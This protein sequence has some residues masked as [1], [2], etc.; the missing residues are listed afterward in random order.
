ML[1][2]P[3]TPFAMAWS[4]SKRILNRRR[5]TS[6]LS[7][8][9]ASMWC[10]RGSYSPW[11]QFGLSAINVSCEEETRLWTIILVGVLKQLC[12]P[13]RLS[14]VVRPKILL[15]PVRKGVWHDGSLYLWVK[16]HLIHL[17]LRTLAWHLHFILLFC[18]C[19]ITPRCNSRQYVLI[20]DGRGWYLPIKKECILLRP[21]V[22]NTPHLI[23]WQQTNDNRSTIAQ[24]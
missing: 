7:L 10:I 3:F 8:S 19:F 4:V 22:P 6:V 17:I 20:N 12:Y 23:T 5:K 14:H 21:R 18:E 24:K 15:M 16:Y 1:V 9:S 13:P 11:Q 2:V